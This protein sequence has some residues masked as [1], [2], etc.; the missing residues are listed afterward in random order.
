MPAL[1]FR[2]SGGNEFSFPDYFSPP[3][4]AMRRKWSYQ[5]AA[6]ENIAVPKK[7]FSG[8]CE[9][10]DVV[11]VGEVFNS[12]PGENKP[13]PPADQPSPPQPASADQGRQGGQ[14]PPKRRKANKSKLRSRMLSYDFAAAG[15]G[16]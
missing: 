4:S 10:M 16:R 2:H 7:L 8:P 14:K 9:S 12:F 15:T 11:F 6:A 5:G 1:S 3:F 13:Q